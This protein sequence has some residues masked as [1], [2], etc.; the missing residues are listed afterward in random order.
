M[1]AEPTVLH[2]MFLLPSKA[3]DSAKWLERERAALF[4]G[5][6]RLVADASELAPPG[7]FVAVDVGRSPL[8]LIRDARGV[9][10]AF[11]NMCRHRGIALA[12]GCGTFAKDVACPYHAWRFGLDGALKVVPQ[13]SEQFPDLVLDD[14]GLLPAAV[15]EWEGMVFANPNAAATPLTDVLGQLPTH[16]GSYRPGLLREVARVDIEGAFNWKLFVE[17]H[18]DVYHLWYLHAE[19]LGDF[20]HPK[21]QHWQLGRNWASYEPLRRPDLAAAA[22][23]QGTATITHIDD[24][25]RLG[26]GAH[27][28]FPNLLMATAAEFFVTYAVFPIAPD[29]SRIELRVR[30]EATAD[31]DALVAAARSF[32]DEDVVACEQ[33]QR[34]V[35]SPAFAVGPLARDH[36][37]PIATFHQYLLEAMQ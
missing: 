10:R 24:R 5:G 30:A 1:T 32:I 25:D 26:I 27:M 8:L 22:L 14:W 28:V 9:L 29:R 36:E 17:N 13:R 11:Q 3:Y 19:T 21:F 23:T 12:S 4:D 18:I 33:I 31:P 20:D 35:G 34:L 7:S 37:A 15:G 6:W 2:P 16:I